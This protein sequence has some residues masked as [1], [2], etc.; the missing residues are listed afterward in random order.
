M[1]VSNAPDASLLNPAN[2]LGHRN[3]FTVRRSPVHGRGVFATRALAPGDLICEYKGERISWDEAVRR[4]PSN[5]VHPD[6][7][8]YFDVGD[9]TVIDGAVGGNSTRWINHACT[10]NCEAEDRN[11]R[12]FIRTVRPI[13]ALEELFIDYALEVQGRHTRQL[14]QRYACHCGSPN[15]RGTMLAERRKRF[16]TVVAS[17]SAPDPGAEAVDSCARAQASVRIFERPSLDTLIVSWREAGR[18]CYSEQRW[19]R[20]TAAAPGVCALSGDAFAPGQ[21]VFKPAGNPAALNDDAR[22]AESSIR[23]VASIDGTTA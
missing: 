6:H 4:H 17:T 22:I 7:T 14:R 18:C 20:T 1:P 10:P 19:E 2:V 13:L 15:C 23:D 8:F 11:G 16:R 9:G 12:I 3:R 5:P 21:I